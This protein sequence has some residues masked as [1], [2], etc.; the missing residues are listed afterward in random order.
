MIRLAVLSTGKRL[1]SIQQRLLH[2]TRPCCLRSRR[3]RRVR[4]LQRIRPVKRIPLRGHK[5]C[6]RNDSPQF[7]LIGSAPHA[8]RKHHIFFNQNAAHVVRPKLQSNL[9]NL[10]PWRQPARLN[11][12]DIVQIQPAHRQRL[13]IIHR[14]GFLHFLSPAPYSPPQKSMG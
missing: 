12:I 8:R 3:S 6:I 7:F 9:A 11:V 5:S 14:R 13:Q 10:D 4:R 1:S 2:L